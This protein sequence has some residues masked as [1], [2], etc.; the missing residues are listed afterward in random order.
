[1]KNHLQSVMATLSLSRRRM[2]DGAAREA[3]GNTITRLSVLARVYDRLELKPGGE[4]VVSVRDFIQ[5]CA[6]TCSRA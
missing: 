3:V 1:V 5:G 4:A 6:T 2:P